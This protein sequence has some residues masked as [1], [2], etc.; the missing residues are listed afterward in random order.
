MV[1]ANQEGSVRAES[2]EQLCGPKLLL[3]K[4]LLKGPRYGGLALQV[5]V[6]LSLRWDRLC[7]HPSLTVKYE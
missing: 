5:P 6:L 2:P 7:P 3:R 4:T 1:E